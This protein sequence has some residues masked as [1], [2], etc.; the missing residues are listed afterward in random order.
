VASGSVFS[1][2][3]LPPGLTL[4]P[5]GV[6]S[7]TPT[8]GGT[9]TLTVTVADGF[10]CGSTEVAY[11]LTV[12][13]PGCGIDVGP[14]TLATPYLAT[15]YYQPLQVTPAGAYTVRVSA[16]TLPT[17]VYL[18]A[19]GRTWFLGG[20]PTT[21]GAYTFALT[22]TK[23]SSTCARTRTYTLTVPTTVLPQ[24][25]CVVKAGSKYTATFGYDNSTGEVV[26]IPVGPD[27][28]FTP[29]AQDRHQVTTSQ[30]GRV[31]NAFSV[32]FTVKQNRSD[33]AIWY[34]RGPD[35]VRRPVNITTATS[36]CQ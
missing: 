27:N 9:A 10:G 3:G 22:A 23:K 21:P 34:L 16:G 36:R 32:L 24:L 30:P 2:I 13:D 14:A 19:I 29:G 33:L 35:G 5:D 31:T 7:G 15:L 1:A 17:G 26:T 8:T 4:S 28:A 12:A 6:L 25:T 18:F 11:T 20:F